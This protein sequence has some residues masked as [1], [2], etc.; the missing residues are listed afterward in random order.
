MGGC[1]RIGGRL[2]LKGAKF[3]DHGYPVIGFLDTRKKSIEDAKISGASMSLRQRASAEV[4]REPGR[5]RQQV[6]K[7][8]KSRGY[9]SGMGKI[10]HLVAGINPI[11]AKLFKED[12]KLLEEHSHM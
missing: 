4:M 8:R 2:R 3:S 9:D 11:G 7:Q 6:C 1:V 5:Q 12:M 10:F